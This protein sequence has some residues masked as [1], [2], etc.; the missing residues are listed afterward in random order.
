MNEWVLRRRSRDCHVVTA[1]FPPFPRG[2]RP[3]RFLSPERRNWRFEERRCR[4]I[5]HAL[6]GTVS[7]GG[8]A[9]PR[10]GHILNV[11]PLSHPSNYFIFLVNLFKRRGAQMSLVRFLFFKNT[12]IHFC[13][14][15]SNF[16][17]QQIDLLVSF[18][19]SLTMT[20]IQIRNLEKNLIAFSLKT[21]FSDAS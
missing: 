8:R 16:S 15:F 19:L 20:V 1:A 21:A 6:G 17:I 12:L 7:D 14:I 18:C 10:G 9:G 5:W 11:N 3:E 2:N 4:P 13:Y